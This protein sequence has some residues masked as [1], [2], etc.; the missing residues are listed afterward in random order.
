MGVSDFSLTGQFDLFTSSLGLQP[1]QPAPL[2][3]EISSVNDLYS[4]LPP[5]VLNEVMGSDG[6]L[7][8]IQTCNPVAFHCTTSLGL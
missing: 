5:T 8:L 2:I 1:D 7:T 4:L 6:L 3:K